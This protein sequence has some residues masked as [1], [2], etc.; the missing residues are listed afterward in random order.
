MDQKALFMKFWEKEAAATRKVLSRV[1]EGSDYRPDPKSR[2]AR[3]IA[4]LMVFEEKS[5]GNGL[6]KGVLEWSDVPAPSTMAEVLRPTTASTRRPLGSCRP[7]TPPAG[8]A[9]S[10]SC[11]AVKK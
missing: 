10:P 2:T 7:L 6:E 9:T 1:P 4:W 11:T 8:K 3:E 5:L